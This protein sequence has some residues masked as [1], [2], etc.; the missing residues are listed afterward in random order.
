ML[1]QHLTLERK[2][3]I[4][5]NPSHFLWLLLLCVMNLYFRIGLYG[6]SIEEIV[7]LWFFVSLGLHQ[8]RNDVSLLLAYHQDS[9]IPQQ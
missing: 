4:P 6:R 1:E 9:D 8:E 3:I 5:S 7:F 2:T